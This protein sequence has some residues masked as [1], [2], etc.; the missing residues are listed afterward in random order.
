MCIRD[1]ECSFRRIRKNAGQARGFSGQHVQRNAVAADRGS[2]DPGQGILHREI[3]DEIASLEVIGAVQNQLGSA[4]Q[5][6]D[7]LRGQVGD[8]RLDYNLGVEGPDLAGGGNG[9]G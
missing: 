8:L 1:S 5:D 2:V 7:I 6:R 4:E 9:F 3:V